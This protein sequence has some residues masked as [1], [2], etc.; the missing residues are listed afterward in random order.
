MGNSLFKRLF[1]KKEVR[2]LFM[3]L[4]AAGKTTTLYTLKLGEVVTTIPTI[5]FNVETLHFKNVDITAWDVGGRDKIRPLYRH[6]YQNTQ[7]LVYVLDSNDTE[8]LNDALEELFT[9]LKEDELREIPVLVLANKQDLPSALKPE[10]IIH[11]LQDEKCMH[12]RQWKVFGVCAI[13]KKDNGLYE[14]LDW[15]SNEMVTKEKNRVASGLLYG[16]DTDKKN[17]KAG[18]KSAKDSKPFYTGFVE[19]LKKMIM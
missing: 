13:D 5:G 7:G 6:Y 17:E 15:L 1:G 11:K 8:R 19:S 3:G 12:D 14:A 18:E 10:E 2:I 4:D 9:V 16:A